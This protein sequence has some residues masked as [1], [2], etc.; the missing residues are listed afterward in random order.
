[1]NLI[2]FLFGILCITGSSIAVNPWEPQERISDTENWLKVHESMLKRSQDHSGQIKVVFLGDSITSHWLTEG[3]QVWDQRYANRSAYN[4]GIGGDT[5]QNVLWRIQ[6][7]E[8]DGLN[9]K[10]VVLLIGNYF[11]IHLIRFCNLS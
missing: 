2:I 8:M 1:M 3:K 5:T 10:V 6:N 7:H 9:P 11:W 4:Y